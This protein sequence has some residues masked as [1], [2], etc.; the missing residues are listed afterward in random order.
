M[1][2]LHAKEYKPVDEY[3]EEDDHIEQDEIM[4]SPT[5]TC[6][7]C[8]YSKES[9]CNKHKRWAYA[10]KNKDGKVVC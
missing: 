7:G 4:L 3:D 10:M 9:Y 2:R 1:P 6:V 8:E 5:N